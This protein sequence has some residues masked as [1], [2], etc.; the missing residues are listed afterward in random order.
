MPNT[1]QHLEVKSNSV[2]F[3]FEDLKFFKYQNI[4]NIFSKGIRAILLQNETT[5]PQ[6]S[7]TEHL[8]HSKEI[9]EKR[10]NE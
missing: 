3:F 8:T 1:Q 6:G 7:S 5:L 10:L 9:F 2:C 4:K